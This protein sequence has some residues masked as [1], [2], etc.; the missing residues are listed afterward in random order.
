MLVV[1]VVVVCVLVEK[2][3]ISNKSE[4]A[5]LATSSSLLFGRDLGLAGTVKLGGRKTSS[6]SRGGSSS[7]SV[8]IVD[9]ATN[10]SLSTGSFMVAE[11]DKADEDGGTPLMSSIGKVNPEVAV[12]AA[13]EVPLIALWFWP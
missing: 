9:V 8:V 2:L 1:A 11:A 13:A 3:S 12:V 7:R 10:P 4:L 5:S 6:D